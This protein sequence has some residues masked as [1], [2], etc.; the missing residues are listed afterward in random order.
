[1]TTGRVLSVLAALTL[2]A[3]AACTSGPGGSGAASGGGPVA[4]TETL[5]LAIQGMT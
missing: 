2:I 3:S 5:G 4:G 1:M